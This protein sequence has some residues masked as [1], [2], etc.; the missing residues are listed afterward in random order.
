MF[1][2]EY[3]P[4]V[5]G[6][7]GIAT[8]GLL[9]G[10]S[11]LG[12]SVSFV[13]PAYKKKPPKSPWQ[14]INASDVRIKVGELI[15]EE[16]WEKITYVEIGSMLMP[17]ISHADYK[18]L[19]ERKESGIN[20]HVKVLKEAY[21][22]TGGY[23]QSLMEEVTRL[24]IVAGELASTQKHDIIHGHDWMTFPAALAAGAKS[25]KPVVLHVH[26]TEMERSFPNIGQD[27]YDLERKSFEGADH[28]IAVSQLTKNVLVEHYAI[29]E[30]KI[31]V[32]HN[33]HSPEFKKSASKTSFPSKKPTIT[34]LGRM[35]RQ[36][37]PSL[38][39]DVAKT[40]SDRNSEIRL[41]MAGDG[42]LLNDIKDKVAQLNLTGK[43]KFP[44]FINSSKVKKL[45]QQTD[46]FLMCASSEPF[47]MVASEAAFSGVPVVLSKQTGACEVMPSVIS[48]ECWETFK[49]AS[50]IEQLISNPKEAMKYTNRIQK[51]VKKRTWKKAAQDTI[52]VYN[53]L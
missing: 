9:Q 23:G 8:H 36:K 30:R 28:L 7:L 44:G 21:K 13:L 17:Y 27:I 26:S 25:G 40:L 20:K 43:F 47:G 3:P 39:I 16:Y 18:K 14:I 42:Y 10:L 32:V 53:Q 51:E 35:A 5:S 29:D 38:W 49:M 37:A 41:V 52:K 1:G 31:T 15:E 22:F 11:T 4:E 6:G 34:F 46:V 33:S 50:A 2:W 19:E 48:F 12:T 24:A 45:L